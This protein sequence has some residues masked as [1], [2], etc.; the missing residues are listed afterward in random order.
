MCE[1]E[2]RLLKFKVNQKC[3][4]RKS[5]TYMCFIVSS[6]SNSLPLSLFQW[7]CQPFLGKNTFNVK[8]L[9]RSLF[10]IVFHFL[11]LEVSSSSTLKGWK[12]RNI[13][14]CRHSGNWLISA[15]RTSCHL[16][17]IAWFSPALAIIAPSPL[18]KR[19]SFQGSGLVV[20]KKMGCYFPF[21]VQ[22]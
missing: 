5:L 20:K 6:A 21:T 15:C 22:C 1:T 11:P 8:H 4:G 18:C 3:K 16:K 19:E 14:S 9:S 7:V 10:L 2:D 17:L 12:T 13:F